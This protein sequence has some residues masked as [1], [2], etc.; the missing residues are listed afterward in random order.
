MFLQDFCFSSSVCSVYLGFSKS[1]LWKSCLLKNKSFKLMKNQNNF[2][3]QCDSVPTLDKINIVSWSSV[4]PP[5]ILC[6]HMQ[7]H[8][9]V[10]IC[11]CIKIFL[12]KLCILK[13]RMNYKS[14]NR[15]SVVLTA[16][17]S[18]TLCLTLAKYT[19]KTKGGG[20][21]QTL[22]TQSLFQPVIFLFVCFACFI[23]LFKSSHTPQNCH[24]SFEKIIFS[25]FFSAPGDRCFLS[26]TFM[27]NIY[28]NSPP[29][30][31]SS[32]TRTSA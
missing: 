24:L 13:Q 15:C 16:T 4:P 6:S 31:Q 17:Q 20:I 8:M 19:V 2:F 7:I 11:M 32:P 5:H 9:N 30:F 26:K 23:F 28:K 12:K 3:C 1:L 14:S 22:S 21:T 27:F 10:Q 25:I 18:E 29:K